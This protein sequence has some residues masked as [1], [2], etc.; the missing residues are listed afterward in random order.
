MDMKEKVFLVLPI[1][2]KLNASP[3]LQGSRAGYPSFNTAGI[4]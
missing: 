4:Y 2:T 1:L 3:G